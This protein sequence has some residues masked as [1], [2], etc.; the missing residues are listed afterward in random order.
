MKSRATANHVTSHIEKMD[1]IKLSKN[2]KWYI[3]KRY[4]KEI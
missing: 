1:L 4:I 3:D 2:I